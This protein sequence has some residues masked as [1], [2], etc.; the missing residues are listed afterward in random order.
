MTDIQEYL[1]NTHKVYV[2]VNEDRM[3]DG[4]LLPRSFVWED[5]RRYTI[6]KIIDIRPAASL[7]AGGVGLRYTV[8]VRQKEA[9]MFLEEDHEVYRW[10]MERK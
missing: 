2:E 1:V 5:G 9:Y 8:A 7:K 4:T 6:D 3:A 10:F